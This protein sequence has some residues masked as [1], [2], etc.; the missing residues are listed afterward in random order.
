MWARKWGIVVVE[1]LLLL[2]SGF[3][4]CGCG[5]EVKKSMICFFVFWRRAYVTRDNDDSV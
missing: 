4:V 1:A 5:E 2:G 3:W